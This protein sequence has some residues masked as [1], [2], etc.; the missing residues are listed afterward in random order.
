MPKKFYSVKEASR[1]IGVS[2]NTIYKYLDEGSLKGKRLSGRGRFKIPYSEIAPYLTQEVSSD[3]AVTE[4]AQ[5]VQPD[6]QKN[7]IKLLSSEML[8]GGFSVG[9]IVLFLIW[10]FGPGIKI[11]KTSLTSDI[12]NAVLGYSGRTFSGFGN[13]ISQALPAQKTA[14]VA[15]VTNEEVKEPSV[16]AVSDS[17][18]DVP[19]FNLK[20]Q[21]SQR[22]S[23]ELYADVQLLSSRTL[24]LL[25][26][27]RTLTAS[28]LNVSISGM[29]QLLGTVSDLPDQKT[30][31]AELNWLD[32]A[33][34]FPTVEAIKR[35]ASQ[36]N[37]ILSSLNQKSL[38]AFTKPQPED[39]NDLVSETETLQAL[40]GN[41]SDS[42]ADKTLYGSIKEVEFLAQSLD[43]IYKEVDSILGSW[44]N[45]STP[46]KEN[47]VKSILSETLRINTL[48]EITEA[49][50]LKP[51]GQD[52]DTALKNTLL[53][54]KG[55]L[56]ANKIH[57][58][59][60]SGQSVMTAWLESDGNNLRV[61]VSNPSSLPAEV[62]ALKY[63]LPAGIK[64]EDVGQID[65]NLTLTLDSEK[66]QYFIEA[67]QPLRAG[68]AKMFGLTVSGGGIIAEKIAVAEKPLEAQPPVVLGESSIDKPVDEVVTPVVEVEEAVE[69]TITPVSAGQVAA[70]AAVNYP[71]EKI[72]VWGL[73]IAAFVLGLVLLAIGLKANL[74]RGKKKQAAAPREISILL[75]EDKL[76]VEA[77][78]AAPGRAFASFSF[79]R[80]GLHTIRKVIVSVKTRILAV[81]SSITSFFSKLF[82]SIKKFLTSLITGF[83]KF[84]A[85]IIALPGRVF[86]A[87]VS[88]VKRFFAKTI[89]VI[90][91][92]PILIKKA[93]RSVLDSITNFIVSIVLL[94]KKKFLAVVYSIKMFFVN[95]LNA[96]KNFFVG[97]ALAVKRIIISIKNGFM[98]IVK[99]ISA[100]IS[101]VASSIRN[102]VKSIIIGSVS[103]LAA[104]ANALRKGIL[105][106][107]QAIKTFFV[108]I[109]QAIKKFIR[110]LK[111]GFVA[112]IT[113]L[114]NFVLKILTS[115]KNLFVSLVTA[116]RNLIVS[117]LVAIRKGFLAVI[118]AI[119]TFLVR[120]VTSIVTFLTNVI[121][122]VIKTALAI[123]SG[124]QKIL[125]LGAT[126]VLKAASSTV[127]A[128]ASVVARMLKAL[129]SLTKSTDSALSQLDFGSSGR[130]KLGSNSTNG[131]RLR[132][133]ALATLILISATSTIVSS[134][135]A[136]TVMARVASGSGTS[137]KTEE[138]G[139]EEVKQE[140]V[141]LQEETT[142]T[143]KDTET[144][145]L[146]VRATPS[147]S[148]IGKVYPGETY[149]LLETKGDWLLIELADGQKGW[150]SSRYAELQ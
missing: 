56:E 116:V 58:G 36:V 80:T 139:I 21:E 44:D 47:T 76:S 25:S 49:V 79:P 137:Q 14:K 74:G 96:I 10:S 63:Y 16:A 12:G 142:V 126:F 144:G 67:R 4:V 60:S 70:V 27:S 51:S 78:V 135:L 123:V 108:N 85:S 128:L 147:G 105:A 7:G 3:G 124:V 125:I 53:S 57:L 77:V 28:E 131:L 39:V 143:I 62:A 97:I 41:D 121:F 43:T 34:N 17:K 150:I 114:T 129:T 136:L 93:L 84:I 133:R 111:N 55:V 45:L 115:I 99:S 110:S 20:L 86:L 145:W 91:R 8:L 140:N 88:A 29:M 2:T 146:R 24:K 32:E 5:A 13:L 149:K 113:S 122:A 26:Q 72:V 132:S 94:L 23:Y 89:N 75:P 127:K 54:V 101:K 81:L 141:A 33:W 64:R 82:S 22:K 1:I 19:D 138:A 65:E 11:S 109:A 40:V 112:A 59:Q 18:V 31:F 6:G 50:F 73:M 106:I 71:T 104:I 9:A 130:F 118:N 100:F 38:G 120:T 117:T 90:K 66:N 68:E 83:V 15:Q 98:A 107:I 46:E 69:P 30:I 148:E 103:F 87:T 52:Q 92:I 35:S 119:K 42:S 102:L 48:P 134:M 95:I 37:F 61:L